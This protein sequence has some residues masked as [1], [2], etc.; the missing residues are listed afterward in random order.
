MLH[1]RALP[2]PIASLAACAALVGCGGS[3]KTTAVGAPAATTGSQQLTVAPAGASPTTKSSATS[4]APGA[5]GTPSTT[6]TAKGSLS[7]PESQPLTGGSTG[8]SPGTSP[9]PRPPTGTTKPKTPG[10]APAAAAQAACERAIAQKPGVLASIKAQ[11]K[12]IC[13]QAATRVLS[14]SGGI[15]REVCERV[16]N[17]SHVSAEAKAQALARC[18]A[19]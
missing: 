10:E 5:A 17:S 4:A 9:S 18:R 7:P 16:V 19:L 11:A 6:S 12:Q 8:K 1:R 13:K 15:A 2:L 14:Q 3:T